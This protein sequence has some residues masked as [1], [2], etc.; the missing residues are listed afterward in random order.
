MHNVDAAV[1]CA[2]PYHAT[3]QF[4]RLVQVLQLEGSPWAFLSSVKTGGAA[5]TREALSAN[6]ARNGGLLSL[7]CEAALAS[8]TGAQRGAPAASSVFYALLATEALGGMTRVPEETVSKLLPYLESG[9]ASAADANHRAGALMLAAQL[10]SRTQLVPALSEALLEGIGRSVRAPLELAA[11]RTQMARLAMAK[12]EKWR[13]T[14][15][16]SRVKDLAIDDM[17][18]EVRWAC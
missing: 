7:V 10:A 13:E 3:P 16:A 9:F 6:L 1:T 12:I 5:P 18:K 11:L 15:E 8:S 14:L 17:K 2:L 4:V